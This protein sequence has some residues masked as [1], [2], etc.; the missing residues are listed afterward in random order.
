M[1]KRLLALICLC[2]M[3]FSLFSAT[4]FADGT[5]GVDWNSLCTYGDAEKT[6]TKI[7]V[8][9]VNGANYIFLPSNIS[10]DSV[11]FDI[12]AP[13]SA[14]FSVVGT[15]GKAV[16]VK[17]G[18]TMDLNAL[19]GEGTSY[20]L[21]FRS[22]VA[23]VTSEFTL[24][25][26][27]SASVAAMYLV[28]SD[29]VNKGREWV[30]SSPDKSNKATG[31]M[32]MQNAD[33]SVVYDDALTQIKGRGNSTW[34]ATKKPYQIK[35]DTK[36]DLLETGSSANKSKTW[37]LLTNFNDGSL[38]RNTIAL[39]LGTAMGMDS[40]M[41]NRHV[42]LYY[43]GE[44]RGSYL[45]TEKVQINKGRVD[46]S[47]LEEANEDANPGVDLESLPVKT[48]KTANGATYMY[49]D[50]MTSPSDITGGYLLEMEA[51]Y[52]A[53]NE[54]CY[55]WTTRR[56][57]VVVKSPEY[58]S[59]EEMDYIASIYQE[60]EDAIY[61]GGNNP[62]TGKH[63]TDYVDLTSTVQCYLINELSKNLDGFRTSAYLYKDAGKDVMTMGPLW[64]Y[65]LSLG[66][67][68]GNAATAAEQV[69]TDGLYT[70][71]NGFAGQLYKLGDFRLAV[72]AQYQNNLYPLL[73][74]VVLGGA[75]AVDASG[76]LHSITWYRNELAL[77][78]SNEFTMWRSS[79]SPLS[80]WHGQLDYLRSYIDARSSWLNS[81]FASWNADTYTEVRRYLDVSPGKWYF[82]HINKVTEYGLMNGTGISAFSPE[83]L[84]TRAQVAQVLYNMSGTGNQS[85]EKHFSD[86]SANNWF[87]P[88]VTWCA[89]EDV[90]RGY[91]D[92]TFKPN[93]NILRQ[94]LVLLLYRHAGEPTVSG[95]EI[96]RFS[97]V[98]SIG[99]YAK[100]AMEWAVENGIISGYP[101]G[102]VLPLGK[103][104]R[105]EMAKIFQYYYESFVL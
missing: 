92:G 73:R 83:D 59:K 47:D 40:S 86:V 8:Q 76:T 22:M 53:V 78:A 1:K 57:Y 43:D 72:K 12:T 105:A 44:Y 91:P 45:L 4:A 102:T 94:D 19:C 84:T 98:G 103:T 10:P 82:T 2:A 16:A 33:G 66:V 101:D 62:T 20:K 37:V 99:K 49:C 65:D 67:G 52:R 3:L 23:G 75:D 5:S 9:Q 42:D 27:R 17:P 24:T 48:G 58:A 35:L 51:S 71:C 79:S 32:V 38:L 88:C 85:F 11:T 87:A 90:V 28:S 39:D 55:F 89:N 14:V 70:V 21:T 63:Y 41:E 64:D 15:K 6:N 31:A 25:V 61:N 26:V 56:N 29:P 95:N 81:E 36:T 96:S 80:A 13:S 7:G 104:T 18:D 54:V 60:Y 30:E 34:L 74:N 93:E 97:D 46:I 69:R 100:T 50:G 77:S 68:S